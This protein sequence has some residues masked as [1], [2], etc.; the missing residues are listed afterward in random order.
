VLFR[1]NRTTFVIVL[2]SLLAQVPAESVLAYTL[3]GGQ[4]PQPGGLGTPI[5][6]TYSYQ[7]LLDGGLRGPGAPDASGIYHPDGPSLSA[8]LIRQSIQAALS[9]WAAVVPVNFVEVPDQGGPADEGVEYA[10]GQFGQIR[11]RHVFIN[12]TDPPPG[13]GQTP[14][15]VAIAKAQTYFPGGTDNLSGDIEFDDSDPWQLNGTIQVPDIFGAATHELGHA[16][17]LN[18][19]TDSTAVMFPVFQRFNGPGTGHLSADD[20]A[21]IQSIYGAGVGSVT[22]LAVPEPWSAVLAA[23]G[24]TMLALR[25]SFQRR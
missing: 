7:N 3:T 24:A 12:G 25:R 17:G 19:S 9:L 16:L 21:G 15:D 18:H 20:I 13:P 22:P 23:M 1:A 11:M 8:N 2:I 10:D 4:W 6:V 14:T 5:T